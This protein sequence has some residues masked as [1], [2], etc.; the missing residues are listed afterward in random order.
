MLLFL[1]HSFFDCVRYAKFVNLF[2]ELGPQIKEVF[3]QYR[4]FIDAEIQQ[5][6][7]EYFNLTSLR[8]DELLST[9][10]DAIPA[11]EDKSAGAPAA[12]GGALLVEGTLF[13][14][15]LFSTFGDWC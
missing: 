9:V 5:R 8:D 1:S 7:C 14:I 10:L 2:P 15:L 12:S 6:A 3:N 13:F 4:S 11:W